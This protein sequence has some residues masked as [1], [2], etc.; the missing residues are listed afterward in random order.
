MRDGDVITEDQIRIIEEM[1]ALKK[2]EALRIE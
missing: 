1:E 2:Q